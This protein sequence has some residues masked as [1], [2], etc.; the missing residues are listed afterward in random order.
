MDEDLSKPLYITFCNLL[1]ITKLNQEELDAVLEAAEILSKEELETDGI[2]YS[3]GNAYMY[4]YF[5]N[6]TIRFQ[7]DT[8]HEVGLGTPLYSTK[9]E[10]LKSTNAAWFLWSFLLKKCPNG[11]IELIFPY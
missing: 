10:H 7:E 5:N 6:K 3:D 2:L 1:S 9:P 11:K 8:P 4:Q